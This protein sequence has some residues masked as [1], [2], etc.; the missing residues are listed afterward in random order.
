MDISDYIE[1]FNN[2][3]QELLQ[4]LNDALIKFEKKPDDL[5]LVEEIFRAAHTLKG[6]AATMN[7]DEVS[8]LTHKMEALL[9]RVRKSII[10]PSPELIDLIF[11]C[12]DILQDMVKARAEG[13]VAEIDVEEVMKKFEEVSKKKPKARKDKH[14]KKAEIEFSK[15]DLDA[16][17]QALSSGKKIYRVK[18]FLTKD[19][20]I[21]GARAYMVQKSLL[22]IGEIIKSI[23]DAQDI[24]DEKFDDSFILFLASKEKKGQIKELITNISEIEKVKV[25]SFQLKTKKEKVKEEVDEN[26]KDLNEKKDI[27]KVGT[28]RSLS[29]LA[30]SQTVRVKI[31]HLDDLVNLAGELVISRS[32]LERFREKIGLPEINEALDEL[33]MISTNLQS[34]VMETRMVPVGNIFNR[35]PRMVRDIARRQGKKVNFSMLGNEIELDRTVLDEIGDPLVHLLRNAVSYGIE[36]PKK[37]KKNNKP[38]IGEINLIARRE[39]N[40]VLIQVSDDGPGIDIENIKKVAIRHGFI[41]SEEAQNLPDNEAKYLICQPGFTTKEKAD[42]V[43]GRGV[44]LDVVKDSIESL[45]GSLY[46]DY[47][48]GEGTTFYLKLPLTLAIIQAL[49]VKVEKQIFAI[50]LSSISEVYTKS[51]KDIMTVNES[52]VIKVY[53]QVI[54]VVR[55]RKIF[56]F[57]DKSGNK[58]IKIVVVESGESKNGLVVDSLYGQQEIVIKPLEKMLKNLKGLGGATVLGDGQVALILDVR[59][60]LAF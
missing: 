12:F 47:K 13:N 8:G 60:L 17:D 5:S 44:G 59:S 55:L 57:D 50:P 29:T 19:C 21:K 33:K 35:F 48:T 11:N 34:K 26:K 58:N 56:N 39:K 16:F 31:S 54:P 41:T 43:S 14:K 3:A 53:D 40:H 15:E 52:E 37:R 4:A 9:D 20:V 10:F 51:L 1:V 22:E 32:K 42:E 24:E 25:E 18:T 2:E 6:M 23:P 7:Y 45:G 49:L 28:I 27:K 38:E 30:D 36:V 46:I